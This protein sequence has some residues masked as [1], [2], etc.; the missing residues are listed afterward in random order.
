MH[1]CRMCCTLLRGHGCIHNLKCQLSA[2]KRHRCACVQDVQH[3]HC[4]AGMDAYIILNVSPQMSSV[5]VRAGCAA[6][7]LLRG[8][9]CIH[10]LKCQPSNVIGVRACVQDVRHTRCCAGM[11]AYIFTPHAD[12]MRPGHPQYVENMVVSTCVCVLQVC[13]CVY[14]T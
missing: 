14:K 3:T 1:A 9:G 5:C 12:A 8:H 6:H 11:D 4:C 10:N 7:T 2:L 13:M